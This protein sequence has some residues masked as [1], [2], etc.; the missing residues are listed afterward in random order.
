MILM[1]SYESP[2]KPRPV[3]GE[4][5]KDGKP[6]ALPEPPEKKKTRRRHPVAGVP[7][8]AFTFLYF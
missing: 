4:L 2:V 7:L 8:F 6:D 3:K 1:F 5:K